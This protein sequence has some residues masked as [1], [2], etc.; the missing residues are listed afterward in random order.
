M[1]F[2]VLALVSCDKQ[3]I[4][5]PQKGDILFSAVEMG[6]TKAFLDNNTLKTNGNKLHVVDFLTDFTGT[7]S[8]MGADS[9]YINDEIVYNG[10]PI[11]G[12]ESGRAYPWTADGT[13][14]F[15]S[16]LS[17]DAGIPLSAQS[18]CN[19]S[20][21]T[22]TRVLSI[23][24]LE[25]NTATAQYDFM[26]ST[27]TSKDAA[28]RTVNT[29][30]ELQMQHLF[31]AL[32]ITMKNTSG[33]RVLLKSVTITGLKN[34]RSATV[35]FTQTEPVVAT[36]DIT[37]TPITVYTSSVPE[38]DEFSS[39]DTQLN[40]LEPF[41][42]MWPQSYEEL[43]GAVINVEYN[44]ITSNDVVSADLS[45]QIAID[46]QSIFR[47]GFHGMDAGSKYSFMLQFKKS[48]IDIYTRILPWDYEEYDWDYSNHSISAKG[49][50]FKDGVLVFYRK[51]AETGEF[52]VEPTADEW[53][54]K[55]MRFSTRNEI[56][57]GRFY[58]EAPTSGRWQIT[59][60]PLSAAQYFIVSPTSGEIDAFT[61][62]GKAEF[63]VKANPEL[64]PSA[65]QTLYFDVAMYYNGEWHD[66]NSEFNRK[67]IKLVLDAN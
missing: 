39:S 50:M 4:D 19:P 23:P 37:S 61:D 31:S 67:N 66:A 58:I 14:H 65:T 12:Y 32:S 27:V 44:K 57:Q 60:Y 52:T 48:T 5:P 28:S 24:V 59:P 35:A 22:S 63:T 62:N 34:R 43:S 45:A 26:Y 25:M 64:I 36:A 47:T 41:F 13:H 2:S 53:S 11:W 17:Y 21:N 51:N 3:K 56:L 38:G 6:S 16:W 46:Q 1:L 9:V 10:N 40:E 8:W 42:L 54:A 18:F 20:Y 30:V 7:A 49:G 29:P 55:T 15:F 33:D